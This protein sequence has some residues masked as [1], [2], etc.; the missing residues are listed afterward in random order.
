MT[1]P[2]PNRVCGLLGLVAAL[3]MGASDLLMLARPV[4]GR[5][6][7]Q[8]GLANLALLPE[9]RLLA[10]AVA[11]AAFS[12]LY[13][14]GFWHVA[15]ALEPAGRRRAFAVFCLLCATASLGGAFHAA[16][17]FVG[18]GLRSA[19]APAA[20]FEV[21]MNWLAAPGAFA[22]LGGSAIFT[23]LVATGRSYYPRWFAACSPFGLV[24][25][26]GVLGWLAPAPVGGYLW[27]VLFNLALAVFFALS[28]TLTRGCLRWK[29]PLPKELRTP[30][31]Q[32]RRGGSQ[33]Q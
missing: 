7:V 21:L 8:L 24:L 33:H 32:H 16:H 12:T 30:R 29:N 10:G 20:A 9:W 27:P 23:P 25:V 22:L 6:F 14:P 18:V 26:C 31:R 28:L 13:V 3:G 19:D 2:V 15:E 1:E 11:G 5:E 4:S 17:G